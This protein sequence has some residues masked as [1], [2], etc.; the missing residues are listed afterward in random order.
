[1]L[2][3]LFEAPPRG[4]LGWAVALVLGSLLANGNLFRW[5]AVGWAAAVI[6]PG[7]PLLGVAAS[8]GAID[9]WRNHVKSAALG[10]LLGLLAIPEIMR[11]AGL[12]LILA[13][14]ALA[15]AW[16]SADETV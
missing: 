3:V 11:Q 4:I 1:M 9:G 14:V 13:S 8:G 12:L 10:S 2:P 16:T 5:V 7:T 15:L 6:A